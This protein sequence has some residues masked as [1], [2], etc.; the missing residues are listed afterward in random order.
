MD[1]LKRV[2]LHSYNDYTSVAYKIQ[3]LLHKK[4]YIFVLSDRWTN[5]SG[6]PGNF[7]NGTF[8]NW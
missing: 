1:T 3:K 2:Q 5:I 7:L 4:K 8:E 6:I